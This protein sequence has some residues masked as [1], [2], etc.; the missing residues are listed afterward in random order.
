M[1]QCLRVCKKFVTSKAGT[2]VAAS[3]K[4]YNSHS[5]ITSETLRLSSQMLEPEKI[6]FIIE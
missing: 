5:E 3:T 6:N 2:D 4:K 1:Q